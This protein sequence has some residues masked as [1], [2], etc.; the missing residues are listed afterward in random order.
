M[1]V[2]L[3][4]S[5]AGSDTADSTSRQAY[6][7]LSE[8]FGPGFNGPL[9]VVTDGG[10]GVQAVADPVSTPD[11]KAATVLVFPTTA[12]QDEKTAELVGTLRDDVLPELS[13][14]NGTRFVVG[15]A[16]A[17]AEDYAS[18]VGDRMPLFISIGAALGAMK[19]VCQD[20]LFGVEGGPIEAYLPVLIFAIVFGP[21]R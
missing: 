7:L 14:E 17:A 18:K 15:G 16:T 4:F 1:G 8:G 13:A 5:D 11:G 2:R 21:A 20:G 10:P 12:P 9:L 6:D 19:L 3:G